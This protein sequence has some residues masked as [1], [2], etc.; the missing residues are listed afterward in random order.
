[1]VTRFR[2]TGL[3]R[4][5]IEEDDNGT[6]VAFADYAALERQ[7]SDLSAQL[8]AVKARADA[9]EREIR[10]LRSYGNKDCTAMADEGMRTNA[11]EDAA[12]LATDKEGK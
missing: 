5:R 1:M 10:Y 6:F 3:S 4:H 11:L 2:T 12:L 9:A 8:A 7:V